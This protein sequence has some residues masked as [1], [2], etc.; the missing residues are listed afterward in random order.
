MSNLADPWFDGD[1]VTIGNTDL[2]EQCTGLY[3]WED[4]DLKFMTL[5]GTVIGPYPVVAG[6]IIPYQVKQV[7]TGT[8]AT[9]TTG[10][11]R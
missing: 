3:V 6:Q 5:G 10:V 11:P 1:E 4:G 9:V 7:M 2:K 8:T